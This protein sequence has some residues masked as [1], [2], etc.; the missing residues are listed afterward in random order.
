MKI[1]YDLRPNANVTPDE[2][3]YVPE[4]LAS[5]IKNRTIQKYFFY[6]NIVFTTIFFILAAIYLSAG[7]NT[8]GYVSDI[9]SFWDKMHAS[10]FN[11][12]DP[13]YG[14]N[15]IGIYT[16]MANIFNSMNL[17]VINLHIFFG[18]LRA[19]VRVCI[20]INF[21]SQLFLFI[22]SIAFIA[23]YA[24]IIV[25]HPVHFV[26]SCLNFAFCLLQSFYL[27]RMIR[28]ESK[29]ILPINLL[30]FHKSEYMKEFMEKLNAKPN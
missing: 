15:L 1:E 6:P 16:L 14:C 23:R 13:S 17:I 10:R 26:F 9:N 12:N 22:I 30:L 3:L 21:F 27:R 2:K 19:R 11:T 20:I 7:K 4:V 29:Y 5:R 18:G 25:L 28:K 24:G 8:K